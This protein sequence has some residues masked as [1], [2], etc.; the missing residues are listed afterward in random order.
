VGLSKLFNVMIE[1]RDSAVNL[2]A[3]TLP[4]LSVSE[5]FFFEREGLT[6]STD[7]VSREII[8]HHHIDGCVHPAQ[9]LSSGHIGWTT[10]GR[11]RRLV[12]G[13]A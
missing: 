9:Q 4:L 2:N 3:T 5:A 12:A 1:S 13:A 10:L 11:N 7:V 8:P 6:L